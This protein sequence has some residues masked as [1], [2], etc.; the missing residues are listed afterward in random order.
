M[1]GKKVVVRES[2]LRVLTRLMLGFQHGPNVFFGQ[3]R[4]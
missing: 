3:V 4:I 2:A 1:A